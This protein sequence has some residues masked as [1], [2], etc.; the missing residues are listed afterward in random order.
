MKMVL[1][2]VLTV[3]LGISYRNMESLL[4]LLRLPWKEPV[5]YHSTIHEAFRRI[6]EAYLKRTWIDFLSTLGA[7]K[8]TLHRSYP[9]R[10]LPHI[11]VEKMG[12]D[13]G[14]F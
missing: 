4:H 9:K 7:N 8:P 2:S 1:I 14:G 5:P 6:P 10:E 12:V 11:Y 3:I 13:E